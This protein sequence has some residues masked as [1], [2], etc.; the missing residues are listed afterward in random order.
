[1][2]KKLRIPS[3]KFETKL[4]SRVYKYTDS[5]RKKA[6][7]SAPLVPQ[8]AV[9]N[10]EDDLQALQRNENE[11]KAAL[12]QNQLILT[13]LKTKKTWD[14]SSE[15]TLS[16]LWLGIK[17][18]EEMDEDENEDVAEAKLSHD[19]EISRLQLVQ[20]NSL[21]KIKRFYSDDY[22]FIIERMLR[23]KSGLSII[24]LVSEEVRSQ[25]E[26][27]DL[28]RLQLDY[29]R[30]GK[31]KEG[32]GSSKIQTIPQENDL[33]KPKEVSESVGEPVV[34][35]EKI[36][37]SEKPFGLR[38]WQVFWTNVRFSDNPNQLT[39]LP[40]DSHES[41]LGKLEEINAGRKRFQIKTTSVASCMEMWAIPEF[42]KKALTSRFKWGPEYVKHWVKIVRGPVRI[43]VNSNEQTKKIIFFAADRDS[44]YR[45][46]FAGMSS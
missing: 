25:R 15:K 2:E 12:S 14:S 33:E 32:A 46:V 35:P 40:T 11:Y 39:E 3:K 23:D 29:L 34:S 19:P 8:E 18:K 37:D 4:D 17:G 21:A 10:D 5:L 26:T 20:L 38:E 45:G 24:D 16:N 36:T 31:K 1:M 30:E 9:L 42:R 41:F 44:V 13:M 27:H 7:H 28:L 6:D 22:D 43:M